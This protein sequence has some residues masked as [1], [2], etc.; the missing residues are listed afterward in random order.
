M[1]WLRAL[2]AEPLPC[3]ALIVLLV[4]GLTV[5]LGP[6]VA[7][8]DPLAIDPLQRLQGPSAK[9]W[10]GTD[11]FGRDL[12]TRMLYG[13]RY[14]FGTGFI[15]VLIGFCGGLPIGLAAGFARFLDTVLM[16]VNDVMLALPGI[17]LA[18]AAVAVMGP[19]LVSVSI[20]VGI[21]AIPI[22][23]R[24]TRSVVLAIRDADFVM[25]ARATGLT[26]LAIAVRHVLPNC[27][28]PILVFAA[29]YF[30]TAVLLAASLSFLGLGLQPP[31][32]EWGLLVAGGRTY[33][34]NA[35]HLAVMPSL[36]IFLV[37]V[38]LNVVGEYLRDLLDPR[39]QRLV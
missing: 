17:L 2:L 21:S 11:E 8:Y 18:I 29:L 36:A 12:L 3:A 14:T 1:M 10:M 25:A 9:H 38:S 34:R 6:L 32:P 5:L 7:P 13:G 39:V 4:M 33:L 37:V 31:A 20:G 16:R 30:A 27:L 23:A 24:L 15:A 19:G 28:S 35:P 22:F 26:E